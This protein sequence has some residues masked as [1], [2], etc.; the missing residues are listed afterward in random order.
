MYNKIYGE[1]ELVEEKYILKKVDIENSEGL[2]KRHFLNANAQCTNKSLGDAVGLTGFG[3][4]IM[5]VQPGYDSTEHHFHYNEDECLYVLSGEGT[6]MIGEEIFSVSEGDFLGYRKGG[7]AHSLKNTGTNVL[8]CI[9]VGQRLESDVVDYPNQ[10]KRI[11]RT[12]G[13]SWKVVDSANVTDRPT[14]VIKEVGS[15]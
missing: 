15:A 14:P 3:F 9:V 6:A 13:L 10:A 2:S 1:V 5:E 11:F 12:K 7:M 8:K 4:H